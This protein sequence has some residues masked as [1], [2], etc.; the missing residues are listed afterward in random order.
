MAVIKG[1][2][3]VKGDQKRTFAVKW[4]GK[5]QDEFTQSDAGSQMWLPRSEIGV[6]TQ[7]SHPLTSFQHPGCTVKTKAK[8]KVA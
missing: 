2:G 6:S 1:Q 8:L 3:S 5:N 7:W 4:G